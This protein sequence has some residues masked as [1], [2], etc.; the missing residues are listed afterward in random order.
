MEKP[1]SVAVKQWKRDK[2]E[3][4]LDVINTYSYDAKEIC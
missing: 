2:S 1:M 3:L 4:K